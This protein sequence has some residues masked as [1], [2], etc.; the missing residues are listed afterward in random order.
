MNKILLSASLASLIF[1][2]GCGMPEPQD[3][4]YET[5]VYSFSATSK[6]AASPEDLARWQAKVETMGII[7]LTK[8]A[9]H[10]PLSHKKH[11][12]YF[13]K[14]I[15]P[16]S[17]KGLPVP[18][19]QM[20]EDEGRQ[21]YFEGFL[22]LVETA[23]TPSP[24]T[25]EFEHAIREGLVVEPP[26]ATTTSQVLEHAAA[27]GGFDWVAFVF[28]NPKNY[29]PTH[30]NEVQLQLLG[31][32]YYL[33]SEFIAPPAS[34]GAW[35]RYTFDSIPGHAGHIFTMFKDGGPDGPDMVGDNTRRSTDQHGH[36]Y[37]MPGKT[38]GFWLPPGVYPI[39]R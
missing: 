12:E 34:V 3:K 39:K 18:P 19:R 26:C 14:G 28:A 6:P 22:P 25:S 11:I 17:M 4:H 23:N 1:T 32:Y 2:S 8:P 13:K 16:P 5:Q 7:T 9:G 38:Q 30:N 37:R 27:K 10:D 15:F 20:T 33:K 31:W 24:S 35:D 29:Y 36:P 21:L